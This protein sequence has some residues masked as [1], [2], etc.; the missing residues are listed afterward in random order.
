MSWA[1]RTRIATG[2]TPIDLAAV[3]ITAKSPRHAEF[4]LCITAARVTFGA[5][6]FK[7][8]KYFVLIAAS[9]NKKAVTLPPGRA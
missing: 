1:L 3:S 2:F 5:M 4:S 7:S 8:C 9:K 6:S